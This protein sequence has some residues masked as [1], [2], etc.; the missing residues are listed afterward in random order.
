VRESVS[1]QWG[2]EVG[3]LLE[4]DLDEKLGAI[5]T[6]VDGLALDI[7]FI[8]HEGLVNSARHAQASRV[9]AAVSYASDRVEVVVGDDG[10][11]FAFHGRLDLAALM[12]LGAGPRTLMHRVE[13]LGGTLTV[14]SSAG[15]SRIE[16]TLPVA[17]GTAGLRE[18]V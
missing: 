7:T 8:V 18:V 15:G 17:A 6:A 2:L 11:G 9:W 14:E 16:I 3:V 4:N 1:S 5:G 12:D 10:H 13:S